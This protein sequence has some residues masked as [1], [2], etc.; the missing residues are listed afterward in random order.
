MLS[1][2]HCWPKDPFPVILKEKKRFQAYMYRTLFTFRVAESVPHH[3][4]PE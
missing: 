1:A 3:F 4:C 2:K